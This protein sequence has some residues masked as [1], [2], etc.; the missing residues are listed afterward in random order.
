MGIDIDQEALAIATRSARDAGVTAEFIFTDATAPPRRDAFDLANAPAGIDR[1]REVT[2]ENPMTTV[3]E[4]LFL[5][6]LVDNIR[7]AMLAA[8]AATA[9]Q[10]D[11]IRAGAER[12]ARDPDRTF[13]QARIH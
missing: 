3:E 7:E 11:E 8:E 9:F 10:L 6:E 5:A 1:V 4:K 2:V 12:A 13:H